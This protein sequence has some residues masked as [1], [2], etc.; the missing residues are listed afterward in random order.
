MVCFFFC[1]GGQQESL[2]AIAPNFGGVRGNCCATALLWHD[3]TVPNDTETQHKEGAACA[4][5]LLTATPNGY[6]VITIIQ[7]PRRP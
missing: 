3:A 6:I 7:Q 2:S 5:D 4:S 1:A